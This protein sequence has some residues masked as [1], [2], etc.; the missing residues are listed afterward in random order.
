MS[1]IKFD[2]ELFRK[3]MKQSRLLAGMTLDEV[4]SR[5]GV[6][7]P[8]VSKYESGVIGSIDYHRVE[9]IAGA[10]GVT[11]DYLLGRTDSPE[12]SNDDKSYYHLLYD[13]PPVDNSAADVLGRSFLLLATDPTVQ[14]IV[15]ELLDLK[16]EQRELALKMIKALS[17]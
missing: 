9:E 14:L 4:A 10:L 7:R 3:R 2:T 8:T 6:S 1:N 16:S 13:T 11:A 15:K 12:Q 17:E 5:I